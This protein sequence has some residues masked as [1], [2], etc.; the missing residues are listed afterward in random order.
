MTECVTID[1]YRSRALRI[2][3]RM[4]SDSGEERCPLA[5]GDTLYIDG[6]ILS[7]DELYT[8]PRHNFANKPH[9]FHDLTSQSNVFVR[10]KL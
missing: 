8:V 5:V 3:V 4:V 9:L 10:S 1:D 6:S 2:I 7:F